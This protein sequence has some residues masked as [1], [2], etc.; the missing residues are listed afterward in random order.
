[1]RTL[2]KLQ[3]VNA[4]LQRIAE[5]LK[6]NSPQ[7]DPSALQVRVANAGKVLRLLTNLVEPM[8]AAETTSSLPQIDASAQQELVATLYSILE[9]IRSHLSGS[10]ALGFPESYRQ[11]ATAT[12]FL[13][14]VL[15]FDLGFPGVW[16][17]WMKDHCDDLCQTLSQLIIVCRF[18]FSLSKLP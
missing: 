1:M 17:Q 7:L 12:I 3:F 14:R 8:R 2:T 9:S 11:L 18:C 13:A 10:A 4:G 5:I 6:N 15:Q 16:I